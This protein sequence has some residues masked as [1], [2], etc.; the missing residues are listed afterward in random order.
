MKENATNLPAPVAARESHTDT[1]IIARRTKVLLIE[2]NPMDV[3]LIQAMLADGGGGTFELECV[4]RLDAGLERLARSGMDLVLLD[5]SLPDSQGL[6]TFTRVHK[7][8]PQIPII[9]MTGLDD[10]NIA[11]N[12]VQLGV[13]DYLVK[14]RVDSLF[15]V[16]SIRHAIERKRTEKTLA[17][18]RNLLRTLIDALPLFIYVKDTRSRFLMNNLAHARVLGVTRLENIHGKTDRDFFPPELADRYHADEQTLIATGQPLL[19]REEPLVDQRGHRQWLVTTKV[20]L[21]DS[22]GK[23]I[24]LVG[25]SHDI[26]ERKLA[27]ADL[28]YERYL[29][30]TLMDNV[31]DCIYFKDSESRFIR[32]NRAHL[33]KFNLTDPASAT[34]KTDFDFFTEEHARQ[35]Y[36]DEQQVIRTGQ[37]VQKEEKETWPDGHATW[38]LTTK[39]PLRDKQGKIVGTFG[40]SR[41]ITERRHAE[42]QLK[43]TNQVLAK[44]EAEL[45]TT[46]QELK[47]ANEKLSATQLHLIQAAKLE[48][49]GTL[50]AGV[51]HEVKNPL[52]T[53]LMGLDYLD[54]LPPG[55]NKNTP[56]VLCDMRDA[57]TRADSIVRG[58]LH[59]AAPTAFETVAY[60]LN[61]LIER[62]LWLINAELIAARISVVRRLNPGLPP[63]KIARDKIE[64]VFLNL[65]LNAIAAMSHGGVLTVSTRAG[66]VGEDLNLA[67]AVFPQFT[68]DD[69]LIIA[70]VQDNGPGI[71][72]ANLPRIFDPFFTTKPVGVG[73]GLGLGVVKQIMELHSG[74]IDIQNTPEGGV[75][76]TLALKAVPALPKAAAEGVDI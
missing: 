68:R 27:E 1:A 56:Q 15:L 65:I 58:L 70:T 8:A 44:N 31:P 22:S 5:L 6:E 4:A 49:V 20:P 75:R 13:Q 66:R 41:D 53:I 30:H 62:A 50:A 17:D 36:Q 21:K 42:D 72:P 12:A 25:V 76:V 39:L 9:V 35:A 14:G 54:Q 45:K 57:V 67:E 34:G 73:T 24:G 19:D 10:E 47:T 59:F 23:I 18:E 7:Q 55:Q 71:A 60:D 69:H 26:T 37:P 52:Q 48:S 40:I 74:A 33:G 3:R 29:L 11:L 61:T 63:V 38:V 64:Q 43:H 2:D 16:R 46:L 32:I 28:E 51:A